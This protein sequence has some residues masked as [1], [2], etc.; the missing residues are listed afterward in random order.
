MYAKESPA[1]RSRQPGCRIDTCSQTSKTFAHLGAHSGRRC[2]ARVG[3]PEALV[4]AGSAPPLPSGVLLVYDSTVKPGHGRARA[5][6]TDWTGQTLFGKWTVERLIGVGGTSAVLQARH[7]NGRRAALKILHP[8]LAAQGR[9][10][11]RFL[12]EGRLANLVNHPG[13]V[14]VLDDF[15]TDD[16]TAVLVLEFV[17]GQ[18]LAALAKE[19]G[20][21]LEPRE[22]VA[23]AC[24]VL[25]ILAV[26]HDANVIHR[27]IKPENIL[28]CTNDTYKLADFGLAALCHELGMLTGTNAALGTPAY[29]SP[30]QARGDTRRVDARADIWG[31]G[32]TM[33]TLLTG[34]YLHA[35][36][37]PRNLVVAA[38][39][40]PARPILS[41][42]PSM[43]PPLA[44]L[45]DR[46]VR[47]NKQERWPN[48]RAM[49]AE[50]KAIDVPT[51]SEIRRVRAA[52]PR[53][54]VAVS[55]AQSSRMSW[56]HAGAWLWRADSR[57]KRRLAGTLLATTT[58]AVSV[59]L[60]WPTRIA[61][62][63]A[64]GHAVSETKPRDTPRAGGFGVVELPP[65]EGASVTP[66][67]ETVT[68]QQPKD[69]PIAR[70][71][72]VAKPR[73]P[74]RATS[75]PPVSSPPPVSNAASATE[76]SVPD[77]VLDRRE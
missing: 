72:P 35:T 5:S 22:V 58:A 18:T 32:A 65:P 63:S 10:R 48:A 49:L 1:I 36:S 8:H 57:S 64:T 29:M 2:R 56:S 41:M 20:G 70:R 76:L 53:D 24:A 15:M 43:H 12:R 9:T 69:P 28:R 66:P 54:D 40:E 50:L 3:A 59:A 39:T 30:E 73:V 23:A 37:A 61:T 17:D 71:P 6:V 60:L 26:A 62:P 19:S 11:E 4:L 51:S 52:R 13:V 38:A 45:I 7:R 46:A 21:L 42:E 67:L 55:T 16:G 75:Q 74:S 31:V 27:D 77:D 68:P 33:F 44:E 14:A 25:E 47:M 34:R